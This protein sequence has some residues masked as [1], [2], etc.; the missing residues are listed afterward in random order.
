MQPPGKGIERCTPLNV[1]ALA[2]DSVPSA[3]K[4]AEEHKKWV[5]AVEGFGAGVFLFEDLLRDVL[6][7]PSVKNE[8]V[9]AV[10]ETEKAFLT[11][12]TLDIL[13]EH[14]LGLSPSALVEQLFFG[15]TKDELHRSSG[16]IALRD[17]VDRTSEW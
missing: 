10:L 7:L 14:L 17:L 1:G 8:L 2:W 13:R 6:A 15:M 11:E 9:A 3:S 5:A 4:A 16:E 12:R